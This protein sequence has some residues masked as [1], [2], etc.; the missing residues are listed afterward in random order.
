[1]K[2]KKSSLVRK[3]I[4]GYRSVSSEKTKQQ[5]MQIPIQVTPQFILDTKELGI[6]RKS[7]AGYPKTEP[8]VQK[9]LSI[10]EIAATFKLPASIVEKIYNEIKT[11]ESNLPKE[12]PREFDAKGVKKQIEYLEEIAVSSGAYIAPEIKNLIGRTKEKVHALE[13]IAAPETDPLSDAQK[14]II[15]LEREKKNLEEAKKVIMEKYYNREID[16][17]SIKN[18]LDNYEQRLVE[19]NVKIKNWKGELARLE[20]EPRKREAAIPQS[21]MTISNAFTPVLEGT[22]VSPEM[23]KFAFKLGKL[24]RP[25]MNMAPVSETK[26][27]LEGPTQIFTPPETKLTAESVEIKKVSIEKQGFEIPQI[28]QKKIRMHPSE[29]DEEMRYISLTYPLIPRSPAKNEYVF[30]Y[31][32]IFWDEKNNSY[33]YN[34][35]EPKFTEKLKD[36]YKKIKEMLE[37]RLDIDFSKL[38]K[39]EAKDFLESQVDDVLKYFKFTL[40]EDEKKILKYYM[41]RDFTG[42]EIIEPMLK[43][44]NIEDISCDGIGIPI[45][46]FHRNPEIGSIATNVMFDNAEQLDSFIIR[47]A[48][49]CGK[50]IS[51]LQ[52]LLDGTL[53]DGSRIQATLGTDIARRGSN[54]TIRK[55]TEEPLTPVH[56]MN[57]GTLDAAMLAYLWFVVDYGRSILVSGGT[58]SGKTSLLNVLSL[59]IRPEKKIVSIEDTAELMLPH[60]HWVPAVARI[61]IGEEGKGEVDMFE[62]LRESLRQRP[63]YIVVGEVRGKEAYI[64]FQQMATGHPSLATIHAENIDRLVDRLTTPPI[65]L[66]AGLISTLDIVVFL[67]RM[68]YKNKFIR[69]VTQIV[70]IADFDSDKNKPITN[71]IYKWNPQNDKFEVSN[72]SISLQKISELTGIDEKEIKNEIQRRIVILEWMRENKILDYRDVHRIFSIYYTDPERLLSYVQGAGE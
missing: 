13:V 42:L 17:S 19:A 62:L 45:Y 25:A 24:I 56:L 58:A 64:L 4:S 9:P 3:I 20:K 67:A 27:K 1:M 22:A 39:I 50:S 18:I 60:P 28:T 49:L 57:Y 33:I 66:P 38:K 37:Q 7:S 21:K 2:S 36:A 30:A 65:S 35:A 23:P 61:T 5:F 11:L 54:F 55:F 41:D 48:Q 68:K 26:L 14:Q 46:V 69:K 34:L 8:T 40:T 6:I 70:E 31:A 59:F 16:E 12:S 51:V 47:L 72:R 43:D 29:D 63:D 52:P 32:Q 71:L 10:K 15:E 53:P 44:P